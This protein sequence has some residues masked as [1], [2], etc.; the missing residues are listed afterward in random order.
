MRKK[1]RRWEV[2]RLKASPARFLGLVDAPDE[3]SARKQAIKTFAV[4]P[5][6]EKSLLVRPYQF[7]HGDA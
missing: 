3:Q 1:L 4:R 5:E 6:D 7:A 2:L